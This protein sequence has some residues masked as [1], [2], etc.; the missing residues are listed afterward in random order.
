MVHQQLLLIIEQQPA[1]D[2]DDEDGSVYR[3]TEMNNEFGSDEFMA[4][5]F[6]VRPTSS[7]SRRE[8]LR[9]ES[10][11]AGRGGDEDYND[12]KKFNEDINIDF[13]LQRQKIKQRRAEEEA[14]KQALLDAQE[15]KKKAKS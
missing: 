9:D 2:S 7:T 5:N 13:F 11:V 1:G 6:R 10:E 12:E 8:G 15:K 14:Q 3:P 4:K